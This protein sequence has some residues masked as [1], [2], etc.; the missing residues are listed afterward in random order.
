MNILDNEFLMNLWRKILY[1]IQFL[2][3]NFYRSINCVLYFFMLKVCLK[4]NQLAVNYTNY[5]IFNLHHNKLD[6]FVPK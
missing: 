6:A 5:S 4:L 3:N 1:N 2:K